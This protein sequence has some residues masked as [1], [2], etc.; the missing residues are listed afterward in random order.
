M[1]TPSN[2]RSRG[3]AFLCIGIAFLGVAASGQEAFLGIGMAF[4]G[5]G[6]AFLVRARKPR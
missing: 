5:L 6:I 2:P 1:D 3:P 4:I